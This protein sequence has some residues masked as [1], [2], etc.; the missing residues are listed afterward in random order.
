MK[1]IE[2]LAALLENER[3]QEWENFPDIE[4]YKDQLLSYMQRP[5]HLVEGRRRA[6]RRNDQQLHQ[7]GTDARPRGQEIHPRAYRLPYGHSGAQAGDERG[8]HGLLLRCRAES[9]M[10]RF[11]GLFRAQLD[12]ALNASAAGLRDVGDDDLAAEI[13]ARA[14]HA[15]ADRIIYER[16]L[17]VLREREEARK[18]DEE[19]TQK[20]EKEDKKKGKA[21]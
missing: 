5:G 12:D 14:L 20:K 10:Q 4:L 19:E 15:Y 13:L 1:E 8:R 9:D 16:M 7:N 3:P 2:A 11:Y 6:H 17:S 18:R 21:D